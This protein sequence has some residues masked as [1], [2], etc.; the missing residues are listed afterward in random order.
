MKDVLILSIPLAGI[1][2]ATYLML[3][4]FHDKSINENEKEIDIQKTK[5]FFPLKIQAYERVILFLER[6]DPNNMIIRTHKNGMNALTLHRELLKIVRD[7]YTHNMSQQVY[8]D[9]KS[10]K[11]VLNA[12]DET[13]QIL[14]VALNNMST[15][16]SGLDLSAKIFESIASK[17]ISPTENAR[18]SIVKEFQTTI[19]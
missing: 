19:K 1:L 8:I 9:P 3:Q 2:I 12:K 4:H 7:E 6:I 10:W 11:I 14:N 18:N 16:S 17:K 13:I 15:E 5:T